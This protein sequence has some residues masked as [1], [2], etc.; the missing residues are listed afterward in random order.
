MERIGNALLASSGNGIDTLGGE[1]SVEQLLMNGADDD[2]MEGGEEEEEEG[3]IDLAATAELA[4]LEVRINNNNSYHGLN[5]AN[6]KIHACM[7]RR[8]RML[9]FAVKVH[10]HEVHTVY[11]EEEEDEAGYE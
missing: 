4:D 11:V 9:E 2:G 10:C 7:K 5:G 3:E 8:Q 6:M 1:G